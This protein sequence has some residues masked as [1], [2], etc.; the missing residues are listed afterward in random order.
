MFHLGPFFFLPWSFPVRTRASPWGRPGPGGSLP[1]VMGWILSASRRTDIPSFFGEWFLRRLEEGRVLVPN[2]F[3]PSQVKEVLLS[4]G[5][6]GALVFWTKDPGPFLPSLDRLESLGYG[7]Y[8]FLFTLNAYPPL[9]EPGLPPLEERI[10]TFRALAARIGS[11]RVSWRYDPIFFGKDFP[12][13]W[14]REK[15][16]YLARAL[17]GASDRVIVS[18]LD[19]YR[20]TLRRLAPLEGRVSLEDP[21]SQEGLGELLEELA[22]EAERRGMEIQACAEG[23]RLLPWIP[24]APCLDARRLGRLFGIDLPGGRHKGQRRECLC[25]FSVDIGVN[26]TCGHGCLYCYATANPE[27]ARRLARDQDPD[28]PSL[29]VVR[30]GGAPG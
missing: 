8:V 24:D 1:S 5:E 14:H 12:P 23:G 25:D 13:A 3:R 20:K 10:E 22:R 17:E 28:A 19:L 21:A 27:K 26:G 18:L 16:A 15:F 2:P 6:V 29:G 30:G 7:R 4:P 11:A 9:V